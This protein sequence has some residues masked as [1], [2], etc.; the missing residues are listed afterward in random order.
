[1]EAIEAAAWLGYSIT[2][3]SLISYIGLLSYEIWNEKEVTFDSLVNS[4]F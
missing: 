4:C 1:M 2:I 3:G